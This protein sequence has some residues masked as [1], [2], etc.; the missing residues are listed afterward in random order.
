M[1][2][3]REQR[4]Y[5]DFFANTF[6][7][8]IIYYT[9]Y[10]YIFL[11]SPSNLCKRTGITES[12]VAIFTTRARCINAEKKKEQVQNVLLRD[13]FAAYVTLFSNE[14]IRS[15]RSDLAMNEKFRI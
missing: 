6:R 5:Q 14:N 9:F 3:F 8:S 11:F 12:A 2:F 15:T 13:F 4:S 7:T 10:F 1:K